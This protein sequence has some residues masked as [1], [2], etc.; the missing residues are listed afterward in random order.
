MYTQIEE[1][2]IM[3]ILL[4]GQ[5]AQIVAYIYNIYYDTDLLVMASSENVKLRIGNSVGKRNYWKREIGQ[6]YDLNHILG[7]NLTLDVTTRRACLR[8][9]G[10]RHQS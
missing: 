7:L 10:Y 1:V 5:L 2:I 4:F 6:V 8:H 9:L 3:I